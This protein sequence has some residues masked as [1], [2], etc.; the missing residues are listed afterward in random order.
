MFSISSYNLEINKQVKSYKMYDK[1]WKLLTIPFYS[2]SFRH[3][4]YA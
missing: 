1:Y 3:V 2:N 4:N